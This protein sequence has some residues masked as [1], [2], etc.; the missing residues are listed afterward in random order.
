MKLSKKIVLPLAFS[1]LGVFQSQSALAQA[2]TIFLEIDGIPGESLNDNHKD[3]IDVLAWSWDI[4]RDVMISGGGT[5]SPLPAIYPIQITKF[6][7]IASPV[8]MQHVLDGNPIAKA[9]LHH[10]RSGSK[11]ADFV[12]I[13]LT[14]VFVTSVSS[15]AA[16]TDAEITENV[17]LVFETICFKYYQQNGDGSQGATPETCYNVKTAK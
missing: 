4:S 2:P 15:G 14:N 16:G 12:D 5:S 3:E 10:D 17:T 9:T 13:S 11:I 8:L 1:A 7:D 6:L